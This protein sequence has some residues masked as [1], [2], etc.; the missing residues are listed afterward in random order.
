VKISTSIILFAGFISAM[1]VA[2]TTK[3]EINQYAAFSDSVGAATGASASL[4][5]LT[6]STRISQE[7]GPTNGVLGSARPVPEALAR[8]LVEVRI[9]TD[10]A[11][12]EARLASSVLPERWRA[13]AAQAIS[14]TVQRLTAA[15]QRADALMAQPLAQRAQ[16]EVAAIVRAMI[17][18]PPA[19]DPALNATDDLTVLADSRLGSWLTIA[20]TATELRDFAGQIGSVFTPA[21]VVRRP[22]TDEEIGQH[23]RLSGYVDAQRRQ[24]LLAHGKIGDDPRVDQLIKTM[25]TSFTAGGQR[26]AADLVAQSLAGRAPGLTAQEFAARYVPAMDSIVELRDQ[27]FVRVFDLIETRIASARTRLVLFLL[28]GLAVLATCGCVIVLCVRKISMP[29]HR[30][31]LVMSRISGGD[32]SIVVPDTEAKNEIGAMAAA[33]QVFKDNLIRTRQLELEA[34]QARA[35]AEEQRKRTVLAL[36]DGFEQA[37]GSIVG[38][39]SSSATQLQATAQAM[40]ATA[41]ETASQSTTVACA[42]EQA[43][44]NVNAVAGAA[45]ELGSSVQEIGRQVDGSAKLAQAAVDEADQTA[46]LMQELSETVARIS[47]VLGLISSIAGQTNLL[48]LNATIEAARAGAAGRGF[49]VVASEVKAL[50]EQTARATEEI[51]RQITRVQG[52]TT[53]AVSAIGVITVRIQEINGVATTIVAAVEEQGAA[54]QEI[55][56]NVAQAAIGTGEVTNNITGVAKASEETGAAAAQV[57]GAASELS[58]QSEHLGAEV[59]RFLETVRAA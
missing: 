58:R 56:R 39:V 51:S 15:R 17:A 29:I 53:E 46:A 35:S 19:L 22:M 4:K 37:V 33:V 14:D 3:I 13:N 54:T 50:A 23:N 7:R 48:A 45:E 20:R 12:D 18:V 1:C 43:A 9:K 47:D 34:T 5:I 41:A 38:Q 24:I 42:A 6:A 32:T 2:V 52:V 59:S 49:A 11:L 8:T 10:R 44:S 30:M 27:L 31:A 21:L 40:T 57:L 16:D 36:A 25:Q 26:L 55:V 28:G